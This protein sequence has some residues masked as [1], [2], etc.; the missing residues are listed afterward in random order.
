[1]KNNYF[2]YYCL[3]DILVGT[4]ILGIT[5]EHELFFAACSTATKIGNETINNTTAIM[6]ITKQ[7][8]PPLSPIVLILKKIVI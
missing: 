7:T 6:H 2:Y 4:L 3:Y 1:M 5:I 8:V